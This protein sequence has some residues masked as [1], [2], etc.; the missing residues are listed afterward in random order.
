LEGIRGVVV[1][2]GDVNLLAS[3]AADEAVQAVTEPHRAPHDGVEH[4]RRQRF[5]LAP[6][7]LMNGSQS[8]GGV[9]E[10]AGPA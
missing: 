4:R 5:R 9:G 2:R 1:V 10:A 8:T 6:P 7:G 3:E